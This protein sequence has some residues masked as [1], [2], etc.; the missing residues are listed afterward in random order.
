MAKKTK[1][2]K[3]FRIG[4][5]LAEQGVKKNIFAELVGVNTGTVSEWVNHKAYPETK[6][7]HLIAKVLN[8]DVRELLIPT[9]TKTGISDAQKKSEESPD[10]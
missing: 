1:K 6:R 5:I 10:E 8:V 9:P 2:E 3:L 7:L 4:V